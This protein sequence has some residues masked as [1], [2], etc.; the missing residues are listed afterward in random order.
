MENLYDKRKVVVRVLDPTTM[1]S[2]SEYVFGTGELFPEDTVA[3]FKERIYRKTGILP[4][5]QYLRGE[6]GELTYEVRLGEEIIDLSFERKQD[7]RLQQ[8]KDDIEI[9]SD[10]FTTTIGE[11]YSKS[12]NLIC[13]DDVLL[14]YKD[15][16]EIELDY[17]GFVIKY[18]PMIS[19]AAFK[20]YI[21]GESINITYPLL[22]SA[23]SN[24]DASLLAD[25]YSTYASM[26]AAFKQ[27][28]PEY[29]AN[30]NP[31]SAKI[32][33]TKI[34]SITI[35]I[36]ADDETARII[37]L[38]QLFLHLQISSKTALLLKFDNLIRF[39]DSSVIKYYNV[40]EA[41]MA[42]YRFC[43]LL[44]MRDY[45][46]LVQINESG[47][48][49]VIFNINSVDVILSDIAKYIAE[50]INPF[51]K[52][53]NTMGR[54]VFTSTQRLSYISADAIT[55]ENLG[56]QMYWY[57]AI[58]PGDFINL[59]QYM[60]E[61]IAL[62][63]LDIKKEDMGR[64]KLLYTKVSL[65]RTYEYIQNEFEYYTNER[66]HNMITKS[67][68]AQQSIIIEHTANH[69][70]LRFDVHSLD[71]FRNIYRFFVHLLY[72]ISGQ[73]KTESNNVVAK[74]LKLQDPILYDLKKYGT[75]N[76]Y[77]RKCQKPHQPR[78]VSKDTKGAIKYWNFTNNVN[79]YYSCPNP[80]YPSFSFI[81][82]VHPL[83]Y[84]LPCCKKA[85]PERKKK[86]VYEICMKDRVY[87][88][89]SESETQRHI[90][91]FGR[92]TEMRLTYLPPLLQKFIDHTINKEAL[93]AI[94][95]KKVFIESR[96][97]SLSL[98]KK[99]I[100]YSKV[101]Q[102]ETVTL[103]SNV[104]RRNITDSGAS[105]EEIFA[106]PSK[107]KID[108]SKIKNTQVDKPIIVY[109][110]LIIDGIYTYGNALL[111][112]RE[113]VFVKHLM[114]K[115]LE[116]MF[117]GDEESPLTT[118]GFYVLGV[119]QNAVNYDGVGMFYVLMS[120]L[121][122]DAVELIKKI[123][124]VISNETIYNGLLGSKI[125]YYFSNA[126]H[127]IEA[128]QMVFI[129]AQQLPNSLTSFD[130]YNEVL[131]ELLP[132]ISELSPII[133]EYNQQ[134]SKFYINNFSRTSSLV[135]ILK[136][137]DA[138][139][140]H[141]TK[142]S[143]NY[144]PIY[145]VML[146]NFFK[147][148]GIERKIFTIEDAIVK[149]LSKLS[150]SAQSTAKYPINL[151]EEFKI[152]DVYYINTSNIC[153]SIGYIKNGR[154]IVIPIDYTTVSNDRMKHLD[155]YRGLVSHEE[156]KEFVDAYNL[157][158]IEKAELS[159]LVKTSSIEGLT[160]QQRS[161]NLIAPYKLI[162]FTTIL[163][164]QN[165]VIGAANDCYYYYF[166][167]SLQPRDAASYFGVTRLRNMLYSPDKINTEISTF[168][169]NPSK[170][171]YAGQISEILYK[172]RMYALF[173]AHLFQ[174]LDKTKKQLP[175]IKSD[176]V[177]TIMDISKEFVSHTPIKWREEQYRFDVCGENSTAEY[178]EGSKL[179]L[180]TMEMK[181]MIELLHKDY[182]NPL[183]RPYLQ[184]C[185]L[186]NKIQNQYMLQRSTDK[187]YYT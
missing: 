26:P 50:L 141:N 132:R 59:K 134:N 23:E 157:F 154:N 160:I 182:M 77:S 113:Q 171:K 80:A 47:G 119:A 153:H 19:L 100:K 107:Y 97:Y 168:L 163:I 5:K 118:L 104:T 158:L 186:I 24:D 84:C 114:P 89:A 79:E 93:Y 109:K 57:R 129:G 155:S 37:D 61:E 174:Y 106:A 143:I 20:E 91:K 120:I 92:F 41:A 176:F 81:T 46:L 52:Q 105:L 175:E 17:Y 14:Q 51:I 187:I 111:N 101:R 183:K 94:K 124:R 38:L 45:I 161:D 127:F 173:C 35:H 151:F 137:V 181:K 22:F 136:I 139:A 16:Y 6:N 3:V 96:E 95:N 39:Q 152:P 130:F 44:K 99:T 66:A 86:A 115:Q 156:F 177:R 72:K 126:K 133:I 43:V 7:I 180:N 185:A 34:V 172:K 49:R 85:K 40:Y 31:T 149:T 54:N 108:M 138:V 83:G 65:N 166:E 145:M 55:Y 75:H 33:S 87:N 25:M 82:G 9:M 36:P 70:V 78:I 1:K 56:V 179:K 140:I 169:Q 122:I 147:S 27:Y 30:K 88:R 165:K 18:F 63:L 90:S 121:G 103:K 164:L 64:I 76:L 2:K 142:P 102:L 167:C 162:T 67:W 42:S 148:R 15:E 98:I 159:G 123:S 170:F 11:M 29:L 144:Y 13:L 58:S 53:L 150:K 8:H 128:L 68:M 71:V 69:V 125:R 74:S 117:G 12:Y 28:Y 135:I 32:I 112:K 48:Y 184:K 131:L 73:I 178:C 4:F 21:G 116:R 60:H 146:K 10:E 62:G 110:N